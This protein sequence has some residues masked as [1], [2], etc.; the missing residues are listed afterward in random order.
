MTSEL[1]T[2]IDQ[3]W[4]ERDRLDPSDR[5]RRDAVERDGVDIVEEMVRID[6]MLLHQASERRSMS[7]E[8]FLLDPPRLDGV[9]AKQAFD[10]GAHA[11]VDQVEKA[12]GSR[13]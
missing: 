1:Q 8:M 2:V 6:P 12:G 3:A 13:V 10:I 9:N 5:S 11:L 7:V 4:E